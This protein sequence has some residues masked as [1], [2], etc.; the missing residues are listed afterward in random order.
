[1]SP[2]TG[3]RDRSSRL[4]GEFEN[5]AWNASKT[6][7]ANADVGRLSTALECV[8]GLGSRTRIQIWVNLGYQAVLQ[9]V[10][11]KHGDW[12][13]PVKRS[14]VLVTISKPTGETS[15]CA[16]NPAHVSGQVVSLLNHDKHCDF[17]NGY[18]MQLKFPGANPLLGWWTHSWRHSTHHILDGLKFADPFCFLV[19]RQSSFFSAEA[20]QS[21]LGVQV[22]NASYVYIHITMRYN[23]RIYIYMYVDL[24][25]IMIHDNTTYMTYVIMPVYLYI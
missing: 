12:Y 3:R 25:N 5:S 20:T 9:P 21:N 16:G 11:E 13:Q 22:D 23:T 6:L 2:Q 10:S 14:A 17:F 18:L 7:S 19:F 1:M 24:H 4:W 8:G 15:G